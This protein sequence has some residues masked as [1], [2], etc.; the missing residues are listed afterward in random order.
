MYGQQDDMFLLRAS[1]DSDAQ[2]RAFLQVEGL[3]RLRKPAP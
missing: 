2:E 1:P 3:I